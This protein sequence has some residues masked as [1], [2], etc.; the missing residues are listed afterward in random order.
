MLKLTIP[1]V[2]DIPD[3]CAKYACA[4]WP[5][6]LVIVGTDGCI[7]YYGGFGPSG[8]KPAELS[9]WL[10]YNIGYAFSNPETAAGLGNMARMRHKDFTR[11]SLFAQV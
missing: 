2:A 10:R 9:D 11:D 1:P 5:E 7:A 4:V 3:N 6:R 8:F